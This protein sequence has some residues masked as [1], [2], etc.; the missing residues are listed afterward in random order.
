[1]TGQ[2]LLLLFV[3]V[4]GGGIVCFLSIIIEELLNLKK[5]TVY[6]GYALLFV[7]TIVYWL[8][9]PITPDIMGQRYLELYFL[10]FIIFGAIFYFLFKS[11]KN[12]KNPT[13]NPIDDKNAHL[14]ILNYM[15]NEEKQQDSNQL[16]LS[17]LKANLIDF[18]VI[19]G[20][21]VLERLLNHL[22]QNDY[23]KTVKDSK[24]YYKITDKGKLYLD[25]IKKT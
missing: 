2:E 11:E 18:N 25:E 20:F 12:S 22:I 21:T 1:M 9:F 23:I 6:I 19:T 10:G 5:K 4:I 17:T 3:L 13:V 24:T 14:V 7:L 15:A 16:T 8:I